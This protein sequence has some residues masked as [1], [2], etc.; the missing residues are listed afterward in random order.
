MTKPSDL[1]LGHKAIAIFLGITPRQVAWMD[2]RRQLPTF[3]IGRKVAAMRSTLT[4]W[5]AEKD[6]EARRRVA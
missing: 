5:L 2:E 3:R 6:A 1:L 4:A